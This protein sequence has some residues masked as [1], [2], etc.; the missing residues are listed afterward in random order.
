M[1]HLNSQL[2]LNFG[3]ERVYSIDNNFQQTFGFQGYK[4]AYFNAYEGSIDT[5]KLIHA[6]YK[7]CIAADIQFLFATEVKHWVS[8]VQNVEVHTQ[9]GALVV[10]QLFLCTNGFA[11]ASFPNELRP[12]RAQVLLTKPLTH[13]I[14][15]TE[16]STAFEQNARIR[17]AL[18]AKLTHEILPG[19]AFEIEQEWSGIM[20]VGDEKKPIIRSLNKNVHAGVR[21]G[22]MGIAIGS[23]V[24][25]ALSKMV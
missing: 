22:G 4:A 7:Q 5:G 8:N 24:G 14:K 23:A 25:D 15:E 3:L 20:C 16:T 6:L 17:A 10:Q 21:M 19:Q 9:H 2:K 11:Q 13:Q 18:I 12:A 1:A